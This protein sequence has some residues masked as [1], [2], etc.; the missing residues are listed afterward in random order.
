MHT[1]NF[2]LVF[3]RSQ[4]PG[5]NPTFSLLVSAEM[6]PRFLKAAHHYGLWNDI[7]YAD[8]KLAEA[9]EMRAR[10]SELLRKKQRQNMQTMFKS[11]DASNAALVLP[12][13]LTYKIVKLVYLGPFKLIWWL[14]C[15]FRSQQT[16]IMRFRELSTGKVLTAHTLTEIKE[17]EQTLIEVT[18]GIEAYIEDALSYGGEAFEARQSE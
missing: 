2:K 12:A 3:K 5:P 8:P 18:D 13:F 6:S 11:V 4:S 9:R 1:D 10:Q 14:Y 7:I 15:A 17:L 16:Q